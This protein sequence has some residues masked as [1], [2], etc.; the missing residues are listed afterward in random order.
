M[1]RFVPKVIL[2][3]ALLATL[4]VSSI[5]VFAISGGC[6]CFS[7]KPHG[8]GGCAFDKK[9]GQCINTGCKGSCF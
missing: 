3:V 1:L 8:V 9:T 5:P 2:L 4:V 7:I 6:Q